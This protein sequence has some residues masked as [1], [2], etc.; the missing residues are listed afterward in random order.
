MVSYRW[1]FETNPMFHI[2][3]EISCVKGLTK[4]WSPF[5]FRSEIGGY[6]IFQL[7]AYSGP[8]D[9]Y[10]KPITATWVSLEWCLDLS[11]EN[12]LRGENWGKIAKGVIAF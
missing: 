7:W 3:A 6:S 2:V 8:R 11:T 12:A 5:C 1:F 9:V 10:C 4:H